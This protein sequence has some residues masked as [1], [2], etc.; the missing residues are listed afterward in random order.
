VSAQVALGLGVLVLSSATA[1]HLAP[2]P[3]PV[4]PAVVR[5]LEAQ[6]Q[7]ARVFPRPAS[8]AG[9]G[10][11]VGLAQGLEEVPV[12]LAS[13][14]GQQDHVAD[15]PGRCRAPAPTAEADANS[16]EETR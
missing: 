14:F 13:A 2:E 3:L 1:W 12:P 10:V 9:L 5:G 6:C 11:V 4:V 15:L 7:R 16:K 8:S